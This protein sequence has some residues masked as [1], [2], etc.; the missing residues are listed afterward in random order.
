MT[1]TERVAPGVEILRHRAE[2]RLGYITNETELAAAAGTI[3]EL[4][5]KLDSAYRTIRCALLALAL[6]MIAAVFL[7]G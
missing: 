1:W 3:E 2:H 4:A 5:A 7:G 6:L